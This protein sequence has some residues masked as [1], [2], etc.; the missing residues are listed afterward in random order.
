M[1]LDGAKRVFE[2]VAERVEFR[3][4][5]FWPATFVLKAPDGLVLGRASVQHV[6]AVETLIPAVRI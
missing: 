4:H 1:H 2:V 5:L 6:E 3:A